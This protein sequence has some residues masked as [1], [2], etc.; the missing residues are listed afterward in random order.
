ML[1]VRRLSALEFTR[2]VVP[3][4]LE[5]EVENNLLLGIAD[6][7]AGLPEPA[8]DAVWLSLEE[9][10]AVVGAAVRTPP[11][12]VAV[13]HLPPG[14]ARVIARFFIQLGAVPDGASGPD[15]HGRDVLVALREE[16]GGIVELLS[17][18]TIYELSS[19]LDIGVPP[20]SARTATANDLELVKAY[21]EAFARELV[22]PPGMDVAAMAEAHVE[23][24]TALLWE[25]GGPRALACRARKTPTGSAI[26]PVY[27]PPEARR[28]GYGA[29]VT[30][31]LARRLLG[32]G[33]RF[34]CLFADQKNPTANHVYQRVGFRRAGDFNVWRL[35]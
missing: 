27:T 1:S 17:P 24:G 11:H 4:L 30:A 26:A 33:D 6:Q 3:F 21:F 16:L 10:G 23:R 32:A 20:G 25:D 7:H 12:Y 2:E 29:A 9:N 19:V 13:N 22:L 18:E 35:G 8:T 14:G 28:R 34:V 5:R 15:E 31:A